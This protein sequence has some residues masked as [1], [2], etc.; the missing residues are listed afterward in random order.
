MN[1]RFSL[2]SAIT[3]ALSAICAII[4]FVGSFAIGLILKDKLAENVGFIGF[5]V[6]FLLLV[7][8]LILNIVLKHRLVKNLNQLKV[9]DANELMLKKKSDIKAHFD[10]ATKHLHRTSLLCKLYTAFLVILIHLAGFFFGASANGFSIALMIYMCFAVL[11]IY[12]H[13]SG[14]ILTK[15]KL[16]INE[17][18]SREEFPLLYSIA[19][20]AINDVGI[21]G[22]VYI[23]TDRSFDGCIGK[24]G[25][26]YLINLGSSLVN[27]FSR[28]ELYNVL[29]HEFAHVSENYTP[30]SIHGFFHRFMEYS[31]ENLFCY[32]SDL[33]LA[34]PTVKYGEEYVFYTFLASE[35]IEAMADK[36]VIEKGN[37]KVFASALAKCNLHTSYE[38]ISFLYNTRPVFEAE[39]PDNNLATEYLENFHIALSE[40]MEKWLDSYER[41]IQPRN[42]SHPIY[43]LRREAVGVRA[44]DV[45][46][47]FEN[48]DKEYVAEAERLLDFTNKMLV[49]NL[50][51]H[52]E[53]SRKTY[54]SEPL[55]VVEAW[56]K[57]K[58]SY[59]SAE[60]SPVIDALAALNRHREAE[61]LCDRIIETEENIYATAYARFFKGFML[62]N[63]DDASGIDMLYQVIELNSNYLEGCLEYIGMFACRCGMQRELDEYR[64]KAIK[65]TQKNID[66]DEKANTLSHKDN[67][68]NDTIDKDTLNKHIEFILSTSDKIKSIYLVRKIISDTFYSRVFIIEFEKCVDFKAI[69]ESMDKIFRYLDSL[70]NEQ[71]SLFMLNDYY[72]SIVKKVDGSKIYAK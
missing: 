66:E 65:L 20:K 71:Y 24:F 11:G 41:E 23:C 3:V 1:N 49:K 57:D 52:Y 69:Q 45:V 53:Q 6:T 31:G 68:V 62:L 17:Y 18:L 72:K 54:Y 4:T 36:V 12:L 32:I 40:N 43:R 26:S 35:F 67:I 19:D 2:K 33:F 61:A 13:I 48:N 37:P 44:N 39:A 29:L 8:I 60:L 27:C 15:P 14:A 38:R 58:D 64:E 47:S 5:L 30:K 22:K 34:Y 55:S 63:Y 51:P 21:K 25:N 50:T 59:T 16:E 7:V 42:A 10:E 28:D 46:I 70:D 56:E 9:R